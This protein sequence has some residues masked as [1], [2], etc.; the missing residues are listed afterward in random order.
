MK[1][2]SKTQQITQFKKIS[3]G[4]MPPNP[5][6]NAWLRHESQ[7]GVQLTE[8]PKSWAPLG[9]SCIRPWTTT[10]KFIWRDALVECTQA[11]S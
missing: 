9:K 5:P 6:A 11:D 4:N 2:C 7:S 8:S 3:R 1:I 10:K